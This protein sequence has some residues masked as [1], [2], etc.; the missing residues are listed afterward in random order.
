[1]KAL[2]KVVADEDG[3]LKSAMSRHI[4]EAGVTYEVGKWAMP[5]IEGSKLFCF[6]SMRKARAFV[7]DFKF[8]LRVFRCKA[9]NP[10]PGGEISAVLDWESV[11]QDRKSVV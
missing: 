9:R 8:K 6:T 10:M 11:M 4:G 5:R 1:M 3:I 7:K 2:Y